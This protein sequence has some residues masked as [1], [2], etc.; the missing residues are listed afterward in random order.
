MGLDGWSWLHSAEQ[1]FYEQSIATKL[2][3][4]I[5]PVAVVCPLLAK[6]I[7]AKDLIQNSHPENK[8]GL[9][10]SEIV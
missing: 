8:E 6:F 10:A 7:S 4:N 3:D 5:I 1:E 9:L 2:N